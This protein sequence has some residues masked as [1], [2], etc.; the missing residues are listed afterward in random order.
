MSASFKNLCD[1][2]SRKLVPALASAGYSGPRQFHRRETR[3]DF[4]RQS[5]NGRHVFSV[6]FDKY[7]NAYFSVQL[8]LE[9]PEGIDF[10]VTSGG[11]LIVGD[12]APSYR[13]WPLSVS[14]FLAER[15]KW[16]CLFGKT[17]SAEEAVERCI[18]LMPEIE[19]WWRGQRSSRHI[20]TGRIVFRGSAVGA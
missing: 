6:L 8:Y 7:R 17:A 18:E 12:V 14:T 5:N 10:L 16:Q 9:P 20:L 13:M 19:G 4:K 3:Y 2:L 1:Q 11:Q 15:P